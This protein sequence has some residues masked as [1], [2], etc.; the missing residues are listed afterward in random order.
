MQRLAIHLE[1]G[2]RE[3]VDLDDVYYIE[4]TEDDTLIRLAGKRRRRDIRSMN[5]ME[6][7]LKTAGFF[8][9]QRSYLVNLNRIRLVR[10]RKSGRDWDVVMAP[11]VNKV[12]PVSRGVVEEL[13]IALER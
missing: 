9:I 13:L 12:L 5:T 10:L 1:E 8:R 7:K 6:Q 11:P 4:A 2:L 3:V